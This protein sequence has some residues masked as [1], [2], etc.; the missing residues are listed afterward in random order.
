M[1]YENAEIILITAV[2][3]PGTAQQTV[4]M[5]EQKP[6]TIVVGQETRF[7]DFNEQ[8]KTEKK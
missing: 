5:A 3:F 4:S 7:T 6:F 8:F 1:E 2:P